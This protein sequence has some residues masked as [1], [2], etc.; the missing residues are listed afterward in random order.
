MNNDETIIKVEN[1][2]KH[3]APIGYR[4][5]L[6][7]EAAQIIKRSMRLI[8][9]TAWEQDAFWALKNVSFSVK[10]GEGLAIIG[11]NGAGKTTLLRL[12][13][14]IIAP[15]EGEITVTGRFTSLIGL[16]AGFD[17]QR[18]G[19]ENIYLNAAIFGFR[20]RQVDEIIDE[21]IEFSE[22]EGFLDQ[23][24]KYYSSGMMARLGFSTA[25]HILPDMVFLDEVLSVGDAAFSQ[26]CI[27]KMLEFK[28]NKCTFLFV[29]HSAGA[30]K[31]LCERAIWLHK[32]EVLM[33]GPTDEVLDAY[34][35]KFLV[36]TQTD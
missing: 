35:N 24:V 7:H 4:P 1:V 29:S 23:P 13:S 31:M 10:R 11:R 27:R 2:S 9:R 3:Y 8:D 14:G 16:G 12:I 5:S 32:G 30:V 21:I 25:I 15:T 20:P 19:R 26:K 22:L 36:T 28:A 18:T 33:D 34:N 17:P 6:R